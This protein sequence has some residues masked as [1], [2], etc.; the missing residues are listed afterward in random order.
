MHVLRACCK[1]GECCC[2]A[3]FVR[4]T[5]T[6]PPCSLTSIECMPYMGAS[7]AQGMKDE[8]RKQEYHDEITILRM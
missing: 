2:P 4:A 8:I 6:P 5:P 1:Y 3:L 7:S